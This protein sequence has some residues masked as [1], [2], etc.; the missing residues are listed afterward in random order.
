[1]RMSSLGQSA[2]IL[3][4]NRGTDPKQLAR[5]L[6]GDLDLI[7]MKALEKDRNRRYGTP[8]NFAE[9]VARYLHHEAILAR[10]PSAIYRLKKFIQRNRSAVLSTAVLALTF[11]IAL[12]AVGG[13]I[14]WQVRDRQARRA[15]LAGQ[16]EL[17]LDEVKK[18]ES[19]QQWPKALAAASRAEALL[20]SGYNDATMTKEVD[21]VLAEL[22]FVQRLEDLR[23][24]IG[25]NE[26][27]LEWIDR[28]YADAFREMAL[29]IDSSST[30][31]V[32]SWLQTRSRIETAY[33]TTLDEWGMWRALRG[34]RS[35]SRKLWTIASRLD[36]DPWRREFRDVLANTMVKTESRTAW[37]APAESAWK[38][39]PT[40]LATLKTLAESV[41]INDQPPSSACL[42]G[43]VLSHIGEMESAIA[44][45]RQAQRRHP[46][47]IWINFS[48][49][50][51]FKY[52]HRGSSQQAE[53]LACFRA[54][55]AVRPNHTW[56]WINRGAIYHYQ[57]ADFEEA[58]ACYRRAAEL[59][60][61]NPYA[62]LGLARAL[63]RLCLRVGTL[64]SVLQNQPSRLFPLFVPAPD[65]STCRDLSHNVQPLTTDSAA[66][67]S[68]SLRCHRPSV[69][70][71]HG[72]KLR[73]AGQGVYQKSRF[74]PSLQVCV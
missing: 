10:P 29:D 67:G 56:S 50:W 32:V 71:V 14:G 23:L 5:L 38:P 61:A 65:K 36:S 41:E 58:A 12:S 31:Q 60:P 35:G 51:T 34:N 42:L 55:L 2:T 43:M 16:I 52:L 72:N 63:N 27:T 59:D 13:S 1:M 73:P 64:R 49:G 26:R 57:Q 39:D 54:V 33:V 8:G 53:A 74:H 68:I 17:I 37:P 30:E 21:E 11:L 44:V 19:E 22:Q 7:V 40:S 62:Y 15:K 69:Y 66:D 9:D 25:R 18:L 28:G 47:D 48:L 3:A 6:A 24:G 20:A 4:G 70:R 46:D 45:L